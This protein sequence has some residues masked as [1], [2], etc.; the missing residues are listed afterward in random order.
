MLGPDRTSGQWHRYVD[1]DGSSV[2]HDPPSSTINGQPHAPSAFL[3]AW[4]AGHVAY[5]LEKLDAVSE[6]DGTLLDN[7][8]IV[9]G[10]ELGSTAHRM[11]RVPFVMAGRARGALTTGRSLDFDRQQHAKLLV[12]VAQIMG[13]D[14][15]GF[16][17]RDSNSGPLSGLA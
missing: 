1:A 8:L 17:N 15:N 3:D 10:R 11:E 13:L 9:W 14:R 7:T 2:I 6:G 16:G 5:L 12:S 4:Y